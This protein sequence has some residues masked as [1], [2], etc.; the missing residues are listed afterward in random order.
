MDELQHPIATVE[1]GTELDALHEQLD[2]WK[3]LF[4]QRAAG[5]RPHVLIL[6]AGYAGL[7]CALGLRDLDAEVTLLNRHDYHHLTTMM[8]EPAV[9]RRAFSEVTVDL[10]GLLAEGEIRLLRGEVSSID[11]RAQSVEVEQ[12]GETQALDY[13]FLVVALG[14]VPRFFDIPGLE[15]HALTLHNWSE[16]KRIHLRVEESLIDYKDHPEDDWRAHVVVGGAGLTGVELAGE[17]ADWCAS[18]AREYGIPP[19]KLRVTLVD[20]SPTVLSSCQDCQDRVIP[21]ATKILES[22]GVEIVTGV[23]VDAIEPHC[24]RLNDGRALDAGLIVWTG[25]VQGAPVIEQSGLAVNRQGRARVNEFLQAEGHPE[26]FVLG[27]SAAATDQNGGLLPPMAQLAA[28]QGPKVAANFHR[29]LNAEPMQPCYPRRMGVF[30][31]LGQRDAL[32][33]IENRYHFKGAPARIIKNMIGYGYLTSLGGLRLAWAKLNKKDKPIKARPAPRREPRRTPAERLGLSA[34]AGLIGTGVMTALSAMAGSLGVP[35][36]APGMLAGMFELPLA[37]GWMMH[38]LVGVLL[39]WLYAFGFDRALPGTPAARGAL[40]G[41]LPFLGAQ[42][43]M[44]PLA[45]GGVFASNMGEIAP[46]VV[47]GS[48]MGHLVYGATVG[49]AYARALSKRFA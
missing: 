43:A 15:E 14:S 46:L 6:G 8:H 29:L 25:G 23:H 16:A 36:D 32:G 19:E 28:M 5:R 3:A 48:L 31:S 9:G 11:L 42:L 41:V 49:W 35:M 39:A 22:K 38:A 18:V 45:G 1:G 26:V 7:T 4:W 44:L 40:Y 10:P 21:L 37:A 47:A 33:V 12:A 17:L 30:L 13:D 27:D 34:L 2:R 20:G 24:V